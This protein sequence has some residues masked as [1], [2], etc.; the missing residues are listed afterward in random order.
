MKKFILGIVVL[1]SLSFWFLFAQNISPD[2]ITISV[3]DPIIMWEATNLKI[4]VMKNWT[5]MTSYDGSIRIVLTEQDWTSLKLNDYTVPNRWTY[6]FLPSDLWEKEFQRWL[7]IKKE[8][9][10]YIE[11]SDLNEN[12]D[13]IL[14]KQL[15]H[16]IRNDSTSEVKDI[17]IYYPLPNT[18]LVGDK[19][20]IIAMADEI[21]NSEAIVYI[22]DNIV[23]NT[24]LDS[25]WSIN[26][27]IWNITPWQHT[28][29]I[30]IPNLEWDIIW[31]SDKIPFTISTATEESIE[32]TINPEKWLLVWDMINI[33]VHTDDM[34]ESVKLKLS[35]RPENESIIMNKIWV[36]QFS[37]NVQLIK[38]WEISLSFETSLFNNTVTH[39][40]NQYKTIS[41]SDVPF[42]SKINIETDS[43]LQSGTIS[44]ETANDDIVSSYLV[45]WRIE[46]SSL[47]WK[48]RST[49]DDPTCP[50][51]DIPYDTLIKFNITPYRDDQT[52]HWSAS[53][54]TWFLISS[55][56]TEPTIILWPSCPIQKVSTRTEKIWNNYYLIR[57]KAEWVTKY[58]IYSSSTPDWK[59][60][61]KV[62]ETKDTSYEYPFDHK[63]K[64][65]IFMYFRIVW[66]CDSWDEIELTWATKIQVWPGEN[67]FLLMCLT[68]LIYSGIKLF[69]QTE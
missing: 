61:V 46:W 3:K 60:K 37:Q 58:I 17:D 65:D 53:E 43:K 57:D 25:N 20:E 5:P 68:L 32:V 35:D 4:T 34:V 13:K 52:R 29:S 51:S 6:T 30:E 23:W 26:Y 55:S 10:F 7:E 64:D 19:V 33:F 24:M 47:S 2:S 11:I 27:S 18:E 54:T 39:T 36:W 67:F 63:A 12:W 56:K 50:F 41:V 69:R 22:D 66:I 15:I 9:T 59:D 38:S 49:K 44:W 62:Y 16:V 31:K 28:L 14:W 42:I 45:D 8:W 1:L 21:P 48:R 40:H